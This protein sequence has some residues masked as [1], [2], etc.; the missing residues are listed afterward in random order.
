MARVVK[1]DTFLY[2]EVNPHGDKVRRQVFAGQMVPDHYIEG[3]DTAKGAIEEVDHPRGPG[4]GAG[5]HGYPHQRGVS[6]EDQLKRRGVS[7]PTKA[8]IRAAQEGGQAA[9][10]AGQGSEGAAAGEDV[11]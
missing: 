11:S 3:D 4:L 6:A 2:E 10:D 8:Q 5:A 9:A 1:K 7:R